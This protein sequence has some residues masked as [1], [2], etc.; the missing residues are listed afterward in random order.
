VVSALVT[1]FFSR[2]MPTP[3][4]A[5]PAVPTAPSVDPVAGQRPL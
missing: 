3:A 2:R 1:Y 5:T 4:P